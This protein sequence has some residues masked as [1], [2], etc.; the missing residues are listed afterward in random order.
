LNINSS[1]ASS[2]KG[3]AVRYAG[4]GADSGDYNY[5]ARCEA[6]TDIIVLRG[7]NTGS[8]CTTFHTSTISCD[9]IE[10]HIGLAVAGT[11]A[12]TEWCLWWWDDVE[13]G[14]PPSV[15]TTNGPTD[16]GNADLCVKEGLTP[17]AEMTLLAEFEDCEGA[18]TTDCDDT[19]SDPNYANT[20]TE[21][22][23]YSGDSDP[24]SIDGFAAGNLNLD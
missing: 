7:C 18:D 19:D 6:G 20:F 24:I 13:D 21:V 2:N 11:N 16:W 15:A 10:D 8:N 12:A 17:G 5:V 1:A 14:S 23:A 3:P 22:G 4:I 9:D